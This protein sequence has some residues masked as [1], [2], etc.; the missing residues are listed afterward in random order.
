MQ[1]SKKDICGAIKSEMSG[2]LET[3]MIAIGTGSLMSI[4]I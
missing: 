3:G 4:V 1:I 2:D